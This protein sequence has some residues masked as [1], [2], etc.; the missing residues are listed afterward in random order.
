[1]NVHGYEV[2]LATADDDDFCG[3]GEGGERVGG[4][5]GC[6]GT[7]ILLAILQV[8]VSV[9]RGKKEVLI[10]LH[11]PQK[12]CRMNMIRTRR[13][14]FSLSAYK[15]LN[16]CFF[17]SL[18]STGKSATFSRSSLV[19]GLLLTL[20]FPL[21]SAEGSLTAILLR[22]EAGFL[23]MVSIQ[24]TRGTRVIVSSIAR[25]VGLE[26]N[27]EKKETMEWNAEWKVEGHEGADPPELIIR[28]SMIA[29]VA[30][31]AVVIITIVIIK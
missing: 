12:K 9:I 8:F 29:A 21:K 14:P 10:G 2:G 24:R 20:M 31:V 22:E 11:A 18:S 16:V 27:K 6:K 1:M 13:G 17:P 3:W 19:G 23:P 28:A 4:D 25:E 15:P 7:E 5:G 30:I 26:S